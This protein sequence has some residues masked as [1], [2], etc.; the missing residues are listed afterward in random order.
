MKKK[1]RK[2]RSPRFKVGDRVFHYVYTDRTGTV[3]KIEKDCGRIFVRVYWD[4]DYPGFE[5]GEWFFPEGL[6]KISEKD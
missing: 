1:T 2:K 5:R 4:K 6:V 3:R